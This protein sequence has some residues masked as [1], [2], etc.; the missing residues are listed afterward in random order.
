MLTNHACRQTDRQ[1]DSCLSRRGILGQMCPEPSIPLSQGWAP[2]WQPH[3]L[4]VLSPS[5]AAAAP[6]VSHCALP[7]Q[8]AV[9]PTLS[10]T[11]AAGP[12]YSNSTTEK[13]HQPLTWHTK[14]KGPLCPLNCRQG[15]CSWSWETQPL[16]PT[17]HS[18]GWPSSQKK[19]PAPPWRFLVSTHVRGKR[20]LEA[21]RKHLFVFSN[22]L[23]WI[24][25]CKALWHL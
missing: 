6:E 20:G 24:N 12:D 25:V 21:L 11:A 2:E 16:L 22:I 13:P 4:A 9:T 19:W 15:G 8:S 10:G 14:G 3:G 7:E 18:T 1:P 23:I 17:K 5:P